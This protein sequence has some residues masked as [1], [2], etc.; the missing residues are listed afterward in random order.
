MFEKPQ[1]PSWLYCK[2][3][4]A[5]GFV[6]GGSFMFYT[7]FAAFTPAPSPP[8]TVHCGNAVIG[9]L[10]LMLL[11]TPIGAVAIACVAGA[12]G[13]LLDCIQRIVR[14]GTG[15]SY[16]ITLPY[17]LLAVTISALGLLPWLPW[18][19]SLRTLLIGMTVLAALLGAAVW[20][21]R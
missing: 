7:G 16:E 8:G 11:G 21:V 4:A 9:G 14:Y 19:F 20:A 12:L 10:I 18:R 17:W 3:F 1:S 5:I 6:V 2:L 15:T 13:G